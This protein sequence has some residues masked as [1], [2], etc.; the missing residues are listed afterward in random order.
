[1]SQ[2]FSRGS[3]YLGRK[4]AVGRLRGRHV[5]AVDRAD[6]ALDGGSHAGALR[7]IALPTVGSLART[8]AL[9]YATSETPHKH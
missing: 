1:M 6:E 7:H 3:I 2:T 8:L 9:A 5:I 4:L